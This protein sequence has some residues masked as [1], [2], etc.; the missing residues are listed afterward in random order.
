MPLGSICLPVCAFFLVSHSSSSGIASPSIFLAS[1]SCCPG[2]RSTTW[3]PSRNIRA[4]LRQIL[5]PLL[6]PLD[7]ER[8]TGT[9]SEFAV[10]TLQGLFVHEHIWASVVRSYEAIVIIPS[11]HR[12]PLLAHGHRGFGAGFRTGFAFALASIRGAWSTKCRLPTISF[13]V[14]RR[15]YNEVLARIQC[16]AFGKSPGHIDMLAHFCNGASIALVVHP[17]LYPRRL[18][19]QPF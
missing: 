14:P 17:I 1:P 13:P 19:V 8:H 3:L 10:A 6:I 2:G 11:L 15:L 16:M 9:N 7:A 4:V 18:S 5:L 12:A